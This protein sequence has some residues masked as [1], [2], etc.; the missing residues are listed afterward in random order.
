MAAMAF[1]TE[2]NAVIMSTG[3]SSSIFL[4]SSSAEMPSI[5]GIIMSTMA[6]SNG[7]VRTRSSPCAAFEAQP[8]LVALARQQRLE[9]LAHDLLVVDDEDG[10]ASIHVCCAVFYRGASRHVHACLF[11]AWGAATGRDAASG[12]VSVKRVPWPERAVAGDGAAVL[13]DDSVRDR[14][15]EPRAFPDILGGEERI[16]NPRELFGGNARSRVADF[17]A[18]SLLAATGDDTQ[19]APLRHRVARVEEQVQEHLLELVFDALH[20]WGSGREFLADLDAAVL[21]LVLEER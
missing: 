2:A 7:I 1:S 16:V 14:Q 13:L 3:R 21:Q 15:A 18:G 4:I 17:D 20:Q 19:P 8:D 10:S 12:N 6:A 5:P 11:N 9:D